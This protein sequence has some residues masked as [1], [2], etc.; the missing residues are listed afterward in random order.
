MDEEQSRLLKH[1]SNWL[2]DIVA[3]DKEQCSEWHEMNEG[4][5]YVVGNENAFELALHCKSDGEFLDLSSKQQRQLVAYW[6]CSNEDVIQDSVSK[7]FTSGYPSEREVDEVL[8]EYTFEDFWM[9]FVACMDKLCP[10][11]FTTII[12]RALSKPL[13]PEALTE[14]IVDCLPLQKALAVCH[15][16]STKTP[17]GKG[18]FRISTDQAGQ[19]I[20]QDSQRGGDCLRAL[21]G[22][23][24]IQLLELGKPGGK[25]SLYRYIARN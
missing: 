15:F 6:Y 8:R 21:R 2:D 1:W 5:C 3:R 11:D 14:N 7:E 25:S 24:K 16:L 9:A 10:Y 23:D 22:L 19:V 17:N 20:G 12:E 13:P 18:C 4:L